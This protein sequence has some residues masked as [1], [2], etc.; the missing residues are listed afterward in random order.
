MATANTTSILSALF[1]ECYADE[2][3]SLVPKAAR[4]QK[5]ASFVS[6]DKQEGNQ[7][8]QPV[9]LSRA[10]GWTLS[11]SGDAFPLNQPEP[12]RT[13][14]AKVQGSSFVLREIISYDAAAKLES[15]KGESRKRAFV[16]GTSYMV[17][18]M[19]ETAAFVLELQLLY[20]QSDL[21]VILARTVDAGTSQTFSFTVGSFIPA[22]WSGLEQGYVEVWD[23]TGA[24][25]R[26][27]SG[28]MQ[29]TAVDTDARTVT[30]LGTEAE[31]DT[32]VATDKVYLRD[33]KSAGMVGLRSIAANAG[34]LFSIDSTVWSLWK[35]NT[36]ATTG[37][38]SFAK[39][40]QGLN[41]PTNRGLMSDVVGYISPK[42]WTDC[43]ND[44]AALRRYADKAGGK[45]EQGAESIMYYGQTG[46][47]ELVPHIFMKPSEAIFV[48]K[49][50]LIRVGASDLTFQLPGTPEGA[51]FQ[52]LQDHAGYGTRCYWNQA[53]FM[54]C[55]S[56]ALVISGIVNSDD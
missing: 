12:A 20:G 21:G 39:I 46:S 37:S 14:D 9:R 54:P 2:L 27:A 3:V 5:D 34:T 33:T 51:F 19:T 49:G 16:A 15:G 50:K 29:V 13:Q 8:H 23:T 28:T 38:L 36:L 42:S 40:L 6:R 11:T 45:I 22:M 1:K 44:L 32:I 41:K 43:N 17:E 4:L 48:P 10:H 35:G 7:Y 30:F 53:L 25:Q 47:I 56:Q 31:M 52:H 26:N 18:N 55:P 24:T